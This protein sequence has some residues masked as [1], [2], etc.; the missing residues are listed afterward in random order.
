MTKKSKETGIW[1]QET[2]RA[3][4]RAGEKSLP[5]A[6]E[7]VSFAAVAEG[8]EKHTVAVGFYRHCAVAP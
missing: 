3:R 5:K 7:P 2:G 4:P 6:Q 1:R 8:Q